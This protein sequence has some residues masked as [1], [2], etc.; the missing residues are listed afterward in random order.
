[1]KK[2]CICC[3]LSLIA[4]RGF[5]DEG[6]WLPLLLGEQVY[7]DMV[8]KGLKLTKEQLFSIN[9]ASL[10]DAVVLFGGNGSGAFVSSQG[11]I[12]TNYQ[13][14][15]GAINASGAIDQHLLQDGFY[16]RSR[17]EEMAAKGLYVECLLRIEDVSKELEDS[18]KGLSGNDRS[19]KLKFSMEVISRRHSDPLTSVTARISALF[20]GNQFLIFV[21]QHFNDIRLVAAPPESI[22][23][24]GGEIDSWNWPRFTGSFSVFRAY[25]G[26]NGQPSDY[27]MDNV[28]MQSKSFLPVSLKGLKEGDFAMI[29]GYPG[30]TNRYESS[31]GVKQKMDIENPSLIGLRTVRMNIMIA[32]MKKDPSIKLQLDSSYHILAGSIGFYT[33][34]SKELSKNDIYNQ[35]KSNEVVFQKWADDQPAFENVLSDWSKVYDDWRP[36]SKHRL[37]LDEGILSSPL[38]AFAVS[39]LQVENALVKQGGGNIKKAIDAATEA[40]SR[41]L[42]QENKISDQNIISAF[43][44]MFYMDIDK[45]QRPIGFYEGLKGSFGDLNDE[46]TYKKYVS[47]IFSNTMIFDDSKWFAFVSN[48]DAN[49]LQED[50]AYKY[51]T[52]FLRNWQGKYLPYYRQ[53]ILKNDELGKLFLKGLFQLEPKKIHYPDADSTMRVTYG[54]VRSYNPRESVHFDCM[55]T[56]KGVLEKYVPGDDA[57]DLPPKFVD[58]AKKRDFGPYADKQKNDIVVSFI[59][60]NDI[61][62][63]NGGSPVLNASGELV[64]LALSGNFEAQSQKINFNATYSRTVC[65]DIRYVLWCIDK[66]GGAGNL[67]SELRLIKPAAQ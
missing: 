34:E 57:F 28:P 31:F 44:K 15:Y 25:A 58:L 40:R 10:K 38:I 55:S 3:V 18:V 53:F 48:P 19:A 23:R 14:G 26:K 65:V 46:N 8:K 11:L 33:G 24:F 61:T 2:V 62:D 20:N 17:Q 64:G 66:L 1:M 41:F 36:Y 51:A 16:A 7:G 52:T 22:G 4:F 27:A 67:I 35:K 13:Y 50:A 49:I 12:F 30:N 29:F 43:T 9:K 59:T 45:N 60:T 5:A 21:Y 42:K 54:N 32:E 56:M 6:M 39:L 63:G 47:S 37:Y